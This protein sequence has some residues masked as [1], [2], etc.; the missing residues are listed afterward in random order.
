MSSWTFTDNIIQ[1]HVCS[2]DQTNNLY[3][4]YKKT[5]D[6]Y[7]R[8]FYGENNFNFFLR[9]WLQTKLFY[10]RVRARENS[11]IGRAP[12]AYPGFDFCVDKLMCLKLTLKKKNSCFRL[13]YFT[14]YLFMSHKRNQLFHCVPFVVKGNK[15]QIL[16][17]TYVCNSPSAYLSCWLA[18]DKL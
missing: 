4:R 12:V 17:T 14:K 10:W 8:H 7:L 9:I 13:D 2:K 16:C 11:K 1:L 15:Y 6:E 3:I 18:Y 5:L